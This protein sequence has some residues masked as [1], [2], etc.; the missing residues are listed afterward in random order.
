MHLQE[1]MLGAHDSDCHLSPTSHSE[2]LLKG[3]VVP[4]FLFRPS[5]AK[6]AGKIWCPTLNFFTLRYDTENL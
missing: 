6:M 1:L 4:Q 5:I 3:V 2:A